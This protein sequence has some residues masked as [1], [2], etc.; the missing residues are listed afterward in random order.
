VV[1]SGIGMAKAKQELSESLSQTLESVNKT[2]ESYERLQKI[3]IMKDGWTIDNGLLT[4]SLKLKRTE[5]EKKHMPDYKRWFSL[6]ELIIWE[7]TE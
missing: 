4:P 7:K 1:L 2:L 6:D 5:L 3:V